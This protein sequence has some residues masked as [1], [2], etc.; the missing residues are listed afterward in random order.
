MI[1][2]LYLLHIRWTDSWDSEEIARS[3][4]QEIIEFVLTEKS[5]GRVVLN[6]GSPYFESIIHPWF[7]DNR[8]IAVVFENSQHNFQ[9]NLIFRVSVVVIKKISQF[10]S[11]KSL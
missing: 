4:Y 5:F 3:A 7:G 1:L 11:C 2:H 6:P 9:V 10:S 8:L